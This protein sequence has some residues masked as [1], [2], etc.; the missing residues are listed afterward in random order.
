MKYF[1]IFTLFTLFTHASFA[2]IVQHDDAAIESDLGFK[3][4]DGNEEDVSDREV[5]SEEAENSEEEQSERE[6]A[7][8]ADEGGVQFWKYQEE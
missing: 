5:A 6:L 4:E 8:E 7:S 1:L 3:W 2:E